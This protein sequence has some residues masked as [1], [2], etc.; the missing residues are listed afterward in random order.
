[1]KLRDL[2]NVL[3]D[4]TVCVYERNGDSM[5]GTMIFKAKASSDVFD[6]YINR[7]IE[8]VSLGDY[9]ELNIVLAK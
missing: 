1:M 6:F 7:E 3:A 8:S 2:I 9:D 4:I 5:V